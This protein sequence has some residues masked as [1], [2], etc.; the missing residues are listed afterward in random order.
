MTKL[1]ELEG[2]KKFKIVGD[3]IPTPPGATPA[4]KETIYSY[5]GRVDG[6]YANVH[7]ASDNAR[8]YICAW[9]DVEVVSQ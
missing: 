7:R 5:N 4:D 9:T 8:F 6:M 3:E 1:Y 2:K